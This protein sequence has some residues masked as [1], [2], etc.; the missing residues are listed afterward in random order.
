MN[1]KNFFDFQICGG[2]IPF[3]RLFQ[4]LFRYMESDGRVKHFLF[5]PLRGGVCEADERVYKETPFSAAYSNLYPAFSIASFM[6]SSETSA[7]SF[8]VTES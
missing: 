4:G 7:D 2:K 6:D 8:T 5:L 1:F 3:F